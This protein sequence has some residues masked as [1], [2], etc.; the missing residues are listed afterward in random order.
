[1]QDE[2]NGDVDLFPL[3]SSLRCPLKHNDVLEGEGNKVFHR[4]QRSCDI[5]QIHNRL[6]E[7]LA[8][9]LLCYCTSALNAA[10]VL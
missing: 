3:L 2:K 6:S 9:T 8:L 1:M 5:S 10:F 7:V 4:L